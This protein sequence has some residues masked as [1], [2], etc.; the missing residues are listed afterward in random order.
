MRHTCNSETRFRSLCNKC[1]ICV[2][3]ALV[4]SSQILFWPLLFCNLSSAKGTTACWWFLWLWFTACWFL[5]FSS[6]LS[7]TIFESAS[8][9]EL[10]S[11]LLSPRPEEVLFSRNMASGNGWWGCT[12]ANFANFV[13]MF[14]IIIVSNV[15]AFLKL[16]W[17]LVDSN[18]QAFQKFKNLNVE[19]NYF[20]NC[21]EKNIPFAFGNLWF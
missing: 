17:M 15:Q 10:D 6:T 4:F 21:S 14:T 7:T 11:M 8:N 2:T 13:L 1:L 9:S 16:C 3:A 19:W 12:V 5:I 18:E 20:E